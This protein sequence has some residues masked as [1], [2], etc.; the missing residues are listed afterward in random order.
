MHVKRPSEILR[1]LL[2]VLLMNLLMQQ[3]DHPTGMLLQILSLYTFSL[4][5]F[6]SSLSF[7][8]LILWLNDKYYYLFQLCNQEK[9]WNWKSCQG[10]SLRSLWQHHRHLRFCFVV[11]PYLSFMGFSFL[12]FCLRTHYEL[13]FVK[14]WNVL[15]PVVDYQPS[16]VIIW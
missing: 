2:N 16:K 1:Q 7:V 6:F 10:K 11:V 3:K 13:L 14:T 12:D 9:R 5:E 8:F 15:R 4:H